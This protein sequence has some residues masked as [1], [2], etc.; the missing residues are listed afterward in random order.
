MPSR[1]RGRVGLQAVVQSSMISCE[2]HFTVRTDLHTFEPGAAHMSM[3]Y[4][5]TVSRRKTVYLGKG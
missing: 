2:D 1:C 3:T 5:V 4:S